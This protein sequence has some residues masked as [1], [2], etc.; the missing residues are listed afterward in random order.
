MRFIS[1]HSTMTKEIEMTTQRT[2]NSD[3][4]RGKLWLRAILLGACLGVSAVSFG[5]TIVAEPMPAVESMTSNATSTEAA[6]KSE[7]SYTLPVL[8]IDAEKATWQGLIS[9]PQDEISQEVISHKPTSN[10][11]DLIRSLNSSVTPGNGLLGSVFTPEL[12]GFDGKHTKVLV[13]GCAVNTPWNGASSLSGF[14]LRRLQ[15]ATVVPGGSSLIYGPNGMSGAVNLTLP[16]AKDLEGLTF[17]Q[18]A[19]SE[20]TRHQEYTYGR[21]S[22]N[23]EHLLGLFMDDYNGTRK[24]KTYGTGETKWDNRMFMYRGRVETDSGWVFKATIMDSDGTLSIPNYMEVFEPWRMSHRDFVVEKDFGNDRNLILRYATYM[25]FSSTQNYTDYS[26][27]TTKGAI[28]PADD[29]TINMKTSEVLYNF[30]LGE[31]NHLTVGGQ[32]QEFKDVGHTVKAGVSNAWLETKGYFISD[33]I[34]ATNK[35]N[36]HLVARSDES[37]ASDKEN[38]W[39]AAADYKIFKKSSIGAGF[40]RTLRFPNFQELYA[41]NTKKT[42]GNENIKAEKSDNRELRFSHQLSDNWTAGLTRFSSDIDDKITSIISA[43]GGNIPGVVAVV[44]KKGQYYI[45]IDE[46][47]ISGWELGLNGK[48][49]TQFDGWLSYT[50]L[51]KA[52]DSKNDLR[53][54]SKPGFR[55]TGGVSYHADKNSALLTCEHQGRIPATRTLDS[56]GN[57]TM[58]DGV[59]SSTCFD[60][61]LRRQVTDDCSIYLNIENLADKDDVVLIQASDTKN[62]AGYLMDPI[63][64]R[65]GRK[66]LLGMELKF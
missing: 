30:P 9:R 66:T 14:P 21:V 18:E 17:V 49:N 37:F 4:Q 5:E 44:P 33:S 34:R 52:E 7:E 41:S 57:A 54:V 55:M 43:A 13:D 65:S 51:D 45:N 36:L 27:T 46:A 25:D 64:Y 10:P 32:K 39:S 1:Y 26:L 15:K 31:K 6:V 8:S 28:N 20:G 59:D 61:N 56:A 62:K 63:Y 24:Y 22:H 2:K 23:N 3:R 50:R 35:L 47:E 19:G 48:F 40:S 16:T 58:Y 42:L 11:V 53:L 12:R 29:V 60:L 38:T